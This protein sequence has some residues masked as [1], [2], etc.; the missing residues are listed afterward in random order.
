[1][2][3]LLGGLALFLGMHLLSTFTS[4]RL[5]LAGIMGPAVYKILYS[6]ISLAGLV[7]IIYG[8]GAAPRVHFW[9]PP[10]WMRHV[11]MLFM[12]PVFPL[13]IEAYLPGQLRGMI[14]HLMLLAVKIW[15]FAHLLTNG[16]LASFLL[17]GSFLV[18]AIYARISLKKRDALAGRR[19]IEGPQRN[20]WIALGLGLAIYGYFTL[21]GGHA[22]LIGVPVA[23]VPV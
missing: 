6:I 21:A 16:D 20:D 2:E 15:A 12:L 4:L 5:R 3:Y 11:T 9:D 13:I 10:Y 19:R 7:A 14:P 23:A 17:F 1:M 8:Y 22:Q 18:W